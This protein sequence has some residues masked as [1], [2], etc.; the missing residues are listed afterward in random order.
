V[1]LLHYYQVAMRNSVAVAAVCSVLLA[2]FGTITYAWMGAQVTT[3]TVP[4][5]VGFVYMPAWLGVGVVSVLAAPLGAKL[6]QVV[7]VRWLQR[8]FALLLIVVSVHLF[9]TV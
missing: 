8:A 4:W 3:A 7:P 9:V 6:A 2:L 5:A 1:P